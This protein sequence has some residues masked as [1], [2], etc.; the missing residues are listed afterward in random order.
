MTIDEIRE[1]RKRLGLS[2]W[3]LA[4]KVNRSGPW[5]GLRELGY[6]KASPD[7]LAA[8]SQALKK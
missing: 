6:V 4:I 2:Q 1:A 7:E 5:L 3:G 8:L